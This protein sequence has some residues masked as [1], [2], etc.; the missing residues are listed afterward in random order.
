MPTIRQ[1]SELDTPRAINRANCSRFAV[2]GAGPGRPWA[3][4]TPEPLECCDDHRNPPRQVGPNQAAKPAIPTDTGRTAYIKPILLRSPQWIVRPWSPNG[5]G[6]DVQLNEIQGQDRLD[7]FCGFLRTL[8][9]AL[10]KRILVYA[11]AP[12]T[13]TGHDRLVARLLA[14]HRRARWTPATSWGRHRP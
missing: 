10:G 1:A 13:T 3:I 11:R 8:G 7:T 9:P 14:G 12:T 2:C 6:S 4:A 5:I